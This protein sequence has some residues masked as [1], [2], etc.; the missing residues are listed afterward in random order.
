MVSAT[1]AVE[2][3]EM[4][5]YFAAARFSLPCKTLD[6]RTKGRVKHGTSPGSV[7]VLT[8]EQKEA[9]VSYLFYMADHGSYG[10]AIAKKSGNGERFNKE[11]EPGEHW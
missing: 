10:W 7:T 6:D 11:F 9:L 5:I 8:L 3:N 2:K 4:A 1:N